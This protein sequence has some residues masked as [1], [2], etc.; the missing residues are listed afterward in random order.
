MRGYRK[1]LEELLIGKGLITQEQLENA[2]SLQESAGKQFIE[3]LISQNHVSET[4][5]DELLQEQLG[6]SLVNISKAIPDPK[7]TEF[8]LYMLARRH[9]LIPI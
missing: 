4:E 6:I 1:R 2:L 5:M 3:I 8:V 9:S 7:L